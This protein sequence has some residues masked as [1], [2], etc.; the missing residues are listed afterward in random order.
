LLVV[1]VDFGLPFT[2]LEKVN[3]VV[4]ATVVSD[5]DT[6]RLS[7]HFN[8]NEW[9][10]DAFELLTLQSDALLLRVRSTL[11]LNLQVKEELFCL[12]VFVQT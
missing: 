6:A 10:F 9:I 11:I 7:K 2:Y 5:D 3:Y 1:D 12:L 4:H 8:Q